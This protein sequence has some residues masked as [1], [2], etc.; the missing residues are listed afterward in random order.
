MAGASYDRLNPADYV[1]ANPVGK[2]GK[3]VCETQEAL[4]PDIAAQT[5]NT[6]TS[7]TYQAALA[8][9]RSSGWNILK[10]EEEA[11]GTIEAAYRSRWF[12]FIDDI[13]IRVKPDGE[14]SRVDIRS[15]SR[16]GVSDP[17]ANAKRIRDYQKSLAT[18]L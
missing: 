6:S 3:T 18:A 7:Q 8:T 14:K 2:S 16:V 17:G 13:V 4:Y 11:T 9:A 15:K 5:F 10:E 1:G 12:G